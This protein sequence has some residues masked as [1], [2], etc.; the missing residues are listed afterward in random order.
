M[1]M[2]PST[3]PNIACPKC[4]KYQPNKEQCSQCGLMFAKYKQAQ[5]AA[6]AER[7]NGSKKKSGFSVMALVAAL[8]VGVVGAFIWKVVAVQSGYE[9]GLIAWVL[10]GAVGFAATLSG[11]KGP[12]VGVACALITVLSIFAGKH[13]TVSH[14]YS[15]GFAAVIADEFDQ[16]IIQEMYDE[17]MVDAEAFASVGRNDAAIKTFMADYGYSEEVSAEAISDEELEYF[18]YEVQPFLEDTEMIVAY[19]EDLQGQFDEFGADAPV[20]AAAMEEQ[21]MFSLVIESLGLL[22][23]VFIVLGFSTAY[24]VG[25]EGQF[26]PA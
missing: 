5:Q 23:L 1:E 15:E 2:D 26:K 19:Y 10:G 22:D 13:M 16:L 6:D 24:R 18:Q 7:V 20:M 11:G 12:A 21:S 17:S 14:Y 25:S 4:Q 8:V 3:S 9:F